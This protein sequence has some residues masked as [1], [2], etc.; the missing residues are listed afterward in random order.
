LARAGFLLFAVALMAAILFGLAPALRSL[1]VD[2]TPALKS[3]SAASAGDLK[4]RPLV[5]SG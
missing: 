5:Q 4:T 2:L 3:G 1:R